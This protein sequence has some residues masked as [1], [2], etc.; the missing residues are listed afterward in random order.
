MRALRD[1]ATAL[2]VAAL[3]LFLA[4]RVA[5]AWI[6]ALT[7]PWTLHAWIA[8][9]VATSA[10]ALLGARKRALAVVAPLAWATI[11]VV[12]AIVPSSG[13][14]ASSL[15]IALL[16]VQVGRRPSPEA[17]AW[18]SESDADLVAI[19]EFWSA[20]ANVFDAE[21]WPH[22]LAS[23]DDLGAGGVAL[24]SR[25]PLRDARSSIAPD[26][27]FRHIEALVETRDGDVRLF[28]V[29]PPPPVTAAL[30]A[31]RNAE[32]AW[33]AERCAS[34]DEPTIVV[35]DVNETPF[36]RAFRGFVAMTGY[37]PTIRAAG[38]APTW[39]SRIRGVDLPA[40]LGIAIDHGF[41]SPHFEPI[42]H[43][44]GPHIGSD[45]RPVLIEVGR[46][47]IPR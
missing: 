40:W 12:P 17:I 5:P 42:R 45:H 6:E 7:S 37:R 30:A 43:E 3:L 4:G 47:L 39:P 24:F 11:L 8:M 29:H 21:R 28:V 19:V 14:G 15:R 33:L 22:R 2:A 36:G 46:H 9:L 34:R 26:G 38:H 10:L 25:L 44:V 32:I 27:L 41:V 20:W 13:S 31:A 1:A 18:L 16:N 35:G 23:P